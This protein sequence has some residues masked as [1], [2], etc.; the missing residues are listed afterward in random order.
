MQCFIIIIMYNVYFTKMILI[1]SLN[2]DIIVQEKRINITFKFIKKQ[3]TLIIFFV[4]F[5]FCFAV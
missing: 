5:V 4:H 2:L 1:I 3:I